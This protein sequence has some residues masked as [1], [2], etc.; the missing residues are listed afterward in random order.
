MQTL[1]HDLVTMHVDAP[2]HLVYGLVADVTRTPEFSP[3]I[4]ECTWLDGA[5]GPA[6]GAR[7]EAVNKVRRGPS[8]RNRPVV[9]E[10][11]PGEEFAFSRTEKFAGTVVWR[12]RFTPDGDGTTVTESYE[13]TDPITR[14]GWFIIG[15]L[16]GCRDRRSE[17]REGMEQTLERL[18]ATAEREARQEAMPGHHTPGQR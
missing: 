16:F 18:R 1:D 8:W 7:F 6:V 4:L 14:I 17:L 15:R 3:E 5:T 9:L 12:Y 11:R 10:V 13:V 2:P